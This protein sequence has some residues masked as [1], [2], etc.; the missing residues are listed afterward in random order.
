[1]ITSSVPAIEKSWRPTKKQE[2]VLRAPDSIF[3]VLGGGAA[4]GG[5]SDLG[6]MIPPLRQFT[7]HPRF[8]GLILRRTFADLEKEIVPR[9]HEWY[10]GM[11]GDYNETKKRWKFPS[12][13]IIQNGHAER[14]A[15]VRKYDS[16][17]YNYVCWDESTHFTKFQYL[18]LSLSRCR[19]ASPDLPAIVRSFTNPGNVGHG[20]FKMRFV[21]PYKFGRKI[22]ID[23]VSNQKR[24]YIPFRGTDNPYLLVNDPL[25]LKRLE[26]LPESERR[27]KLDGSWDAYEG[28]VFSEFRVAKLSDEPE[29]AIHVISPFPIPDWWPRI[30][31]IDWGWNAMTFIIWGAVSPSGRLFIYRTWSW[32]RTPIKI[33]AKEASDLTKDEVIDDLVVCHS[34]G[35]HRGEELTIQEQIYDAFD[36]KY[37]IRLG[38]RDRIGGKNLLHEY[39]RW[40]QKPTSTSKE[41]VFD[42]EL[43]S[44]ILRNRGEEAYSDY[45]SLFATPPIETNI[46]KL[47]IFTYGPEGRKNDELIDCI[48]SCV[49]KES[50]PEDV[51]EFSGDDP[52]DC[53]RMLVNAAS[54]L[55]SDSPERMLEIQKRNEVV[56]ELK[57]TANQTNFYMQMQKL[58]VDS[59]E[60]F[61]VRRHSPIKRYKSSTM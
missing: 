55:S 60:V 31:A 9:Q 13:A 43:A 15:D 24:L 32:S 11:G 49:P 33:W 10:G 17:E 57:V 50:N 52:Y 36:G 59:P 58:D 47:Q 30:I 61:S 22:I 25:Y 23:N 34:A 1:M 28:Q 7:E 38:E 20:F 8:K 53:V 2:E 44:R 27:A 46:P 45:M 21:D 19:S 18:Y 16:A 35:Q 56:N 54:R 42:S 48:P 29:N 3:E 5:K 41:L 14:E 39:L 4:G 12:G 40:Q 26:G 37:A 51:E 6:I